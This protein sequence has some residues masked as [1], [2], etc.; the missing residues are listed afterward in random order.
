MK[1]GLIPINIG[2]Q[3]L[4][5]IIGTAQLAE[6][7]GVESV[8]TFE[9]VIVPEDYASKYPYNES[10]KMGAEPDTV[11]VDPLIALSAV[12]AAT[13]T[14]RLGTGV[15]IVAQANP[16]LLAKQVA[17]L[18]FISGGRFMLGAGIG[19]LKEEFR[20]MGTPF[21][22]RGARFDDYIAAMR[23]VW[24]GETVEHQSEF[25]DW[26]GFKSYPTPVQ[27]PFPVIMGGN[28][29][30]IFERIA[31]LGNGWFAPTADAAELAP[32]L[33]QLRA[34]CKAADRNY[35]ELEI[36][37]MWPGGGLEALK[38]MQDLGAA[39]A[40]VPIFALGADP[41]DGIKKLGDEV[42]AKL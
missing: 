27:D 14:L 18:D 30:K 25:V 5:Q 33:D 37:V 13:K 19:W 42:I 38:P 4:E 9:H 24:S 34:A 12:A 15:N 6:S 26:T 21:E 35:D 36:T 10:G 31:T 7:V 28:K 3:S 29:G 39:R 16:M 8:W 22:K 2:F 41:V 20:A 17:S 1:I 23:K 11:F 32:Q 40:V